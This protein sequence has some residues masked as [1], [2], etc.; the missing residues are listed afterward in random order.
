MPELSAPRLSVIL[1]AIVQFTALIRFERPT[2]R[3]DDVMTCVVLV[4]IPKADALRIT[5]AAALS[6]LKPVNRLQFYKI[7]SDGFDNSPTT[8]SSPDAPWL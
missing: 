2:P 3:I 4:G 6:T 7:M 5:V 8:G 1:P